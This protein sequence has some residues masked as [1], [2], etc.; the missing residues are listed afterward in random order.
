MDAELLDLPLVGRVPDA[1]RSNGIQELALAQDLGIGI[2]H[3]V[4][5]GEELLH[6]GRVA[7]KHG[8]ARLV[9]ETADF[10][11]GRLHVGETADGTVVVPAAADY[12]SWTERIANF[13]SRPDLAGAKARRLWLAGKLSPW[14]RQ[15]LLTRQWII[16][17]GVSI[18]PPA[19]PAAPRS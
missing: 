6:R 4:V 17:E 16:E 10:F 11:L 13:A 8:V 12:V 18:V 9:V 1:P 15:E 2:G 5:L 7:S 14:T 3:Q 19:S